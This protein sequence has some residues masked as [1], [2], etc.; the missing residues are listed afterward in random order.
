[1][2]DAAGRAALRCEAA[3][4]RF[5]WALIAWQFAELKAGFDPNQPRVPAG[6]PTGGQ[7]T[8]ADA[9]LFAEPIDLLEE[10]EKGGHAYAR[11]V[12]KSDAFLKRRVRQKQRLARHA[13]KVPRLGPFVKLAVSA[14]MYEASSFTSLAS[15]E[16]LVTAALATDQPLLDRIAFGE[17]RRKAKFKLTSRSK[18]GRVAYARGLAR[19][20]IRD[21]YSVVVVVRHDP[22]DEK[23]YRIVTAYVE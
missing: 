2:P 21:A 7:W 6:F 17:G 8:D 10:E 23:G 13:A 18:V 1:M 4:L 22:N 3:A 19:A 12:G 9:S 11:H 14:N 16:K 5:K 20:K 15:A